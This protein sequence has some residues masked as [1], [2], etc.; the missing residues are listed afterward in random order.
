MSAVKNE[1]IEI[2]NPHQIK[3]TLKDKMKMSLK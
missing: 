1:E 3:L 2:E